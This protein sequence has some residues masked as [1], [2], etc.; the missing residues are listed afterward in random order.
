[1]IVCAGFAAAVENVM[2][3]MAEDIST[4]AQMYVMYAAEQADVLIVKDQA[5]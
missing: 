4:W 3:V 1:M 2:N 5:E